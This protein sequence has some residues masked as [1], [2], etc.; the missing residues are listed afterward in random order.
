M[1][2]ADLGQII[3]S[4]ILCCWRGVDFTEEEFAK[5]TFRFLVL[6]NSEKLRYYW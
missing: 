5:Q 2:V 3:G 6:E 1:V 4:R